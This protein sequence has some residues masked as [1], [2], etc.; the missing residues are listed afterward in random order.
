MKSPKTQKKNMNSPLTDK[1]KRVESQYSVPKKNLINKKI[2]QIMSL[3][4]E[5]SSLIK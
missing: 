3:A 2:N 4:N 5:I 1:S